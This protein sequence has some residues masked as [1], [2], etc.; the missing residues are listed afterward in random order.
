[1]RRCGSVLTVDMEALRHVKEE[2]DPDERQQPQKEV[3]VDCAIIGVAQSSHSNRRKIRL[4]KR[5]KD[6]RKRE[7]LREHRTNTRVLARPLNSNED[8][9]APRNLASTGELQVLQQAMGISNVSNAST[10][11]V[12]QDRPQYVGI[13]PQSLH[14]LEDEED[15]K[16]QKNEENGKI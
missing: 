6:R 2:K 14:R 11:Q 10:N 4:Q 7:S 8:G 3:G 12:N 9:N 16:E 15:K 5:Q 13:L 1:M